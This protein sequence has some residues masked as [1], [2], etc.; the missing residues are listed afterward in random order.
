MLKSWLSAA[1][2]GV[3][4]LFLDP[5]ISSAQ[6]RSGNVSGIYAGANYNPYRGYGGSYAMPGRYPYS[7]PG[8]YYGPAV[9]YYYA[10]PLIDGP[11]PAF[12]DVRV[13]PG[14]EVFFDGDKTSQTGGDRT[15]V[16]PALQ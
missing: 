9:S 10:P 5:G 16:S 4:G 13:P 6:V 11:M 7:S 8:Y 2:V 12:M 15:F 14:A 1:A 3:L